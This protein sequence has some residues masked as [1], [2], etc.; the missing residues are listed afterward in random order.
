MTSD[1]DERSNDIV[2]AI[3]LVLMLV[4]SIVCIHA[5]S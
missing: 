5:C 1:Q 4:I 2:M 3:G